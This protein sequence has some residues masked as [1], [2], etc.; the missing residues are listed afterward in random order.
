MLNLSKNVVRLFD[1]VERGREAEFKIAI[2]TLKGL[3]DRQLNDIGIARNNIENVV[4]NGKAVND[5][6]FS[7]NSVA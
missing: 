3:S 6:N 7:Q 1:K 2:R 5:A 4:R